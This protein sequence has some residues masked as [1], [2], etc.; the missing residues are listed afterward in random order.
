MKKIFIV[1][2]VLIL[3]VFSG[4]KEESLIGPIDHDTQPP[5]PVV[6]KKVTAV[7]GGFDVV[8]DLPGDKDLLMVK[9][10]YDIRE[11][12]Q[13]DVRASYFT[14]EMEVLGFGDTLEHQVSLYA[15][16]R[17]N[18]ISEPVTFTGHPLTPPVHMIAKSIKIVPDWGGAKYTWVNTTKSP[19]AIMLV[20]PDSLGRMQVAHTVYT[21]VDTGTYSLRGY[22]TIPTH[23]YAIVRD[24]WDNLSDTVKPDTPDYTVIPWYEVRLD[25]TKFR[26]VS[27]DNDTRWDAW[28]GKPEF[29]WDDDFTTFGHTQGDHPNPQII[30]IDL[31]VKVILSRFKVYQRSHS[32]TYYAYNHGNPKKYDVY[33]SL[34][35]P[36]QSGDLSQWP[37]LRETCVSWKP[38]G[39]PNGQNTDEDIQHFMEGDEY[40]VTNLVPIRYFRLA[41]LET[42]DGAG[43]VDPC[44]FTFWGNVL[45]EYNK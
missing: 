44:E 11:G 35:I 16:D 36:D 40:P 39:L 1:F 14:N 5:G 8:Y 31:G 38:S 41:V 25:K 29:L 30:T 26:L 17:S 20:A 27:L 7:P 4:C 9:A 13:S 33:G 15:V 19:V 24:H 18:N 10:V 22:D 2:S 34:T 43:F 23:F 28:E 3:I 6:V 32:Q 12:V 45:E 42:W 21:S 37:T